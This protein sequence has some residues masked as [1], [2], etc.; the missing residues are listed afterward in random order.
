[1]AN[2]SETGEKYWADP[3]FINED[4]S[5][6]LDPD[7]TAT[8][9]PKSPDYAEKT[10]HVT[11]KRPQDI[12]TV[13]EPKMCVNGVEPADVEQGALGDC[14]LL[15]SFMLLASQPQLLQNLIVYDGIDKGF[16][17]FQFFKNGKWQQI[18]VDTLIP[19]SET[20]KSIAYARSHNPQEF[21]LPLLEKAYAKL[22]G[23]YE[24]INGGSMAVGLVDVS[25]GVSEKFVLT[26]PDM[27]GPLANGQFFRQ[28]LKYNSQGYLIGCANSQKDD[29]GNTHDGNGPQGILF[30]HAYGLERIEDFKDINLQILRIRNPWGHGEWEG[31]FKDED[32]AWDEFKNL[33][34]RL[35]YTFKNDGNWWMM[36]EDWKAHFNRVYVCKLFPQS[37][38]QFSV[39]GKWE[40]NT[41][42]GPYPVQPDRDEEVKSSHAKI[43]S[44]DRWFNNP[45]YRFTV[46][47]KTQ[48]IISLMQEDFNTSKKEYIPVNFTVVRVKS[49]RDRLYDLDQ[50]DIVC[51]AAEGG[52]RFSQR[53]ITKTLTLEPTYNKKNVH[54]IIIPNTE[55]E[56]KNPERP[57]FLRI[58]SSE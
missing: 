55:N 22:Q 15:S 14:W 52:Q 24:S 11:W 10:G 39:P 41:A 6:Y 47:K 36:W 34:D 8:S 35:N 4:V 33:R 13:G 18:I 25:G 5:L 9:E 58:F 54:Y 31:R 17:V 21:W 37:W 49:R 26:D 40:G 7:K 50:D 16:A 12:Y 46:T 57:F 38:S 19:Y 32:E 44:N 48:V 1:L 27:Q 56:G 51:N 45:Q 20:Q 43:D 28:L 23:S 3:E 2:L 29:H 53:E 42:G 30:N